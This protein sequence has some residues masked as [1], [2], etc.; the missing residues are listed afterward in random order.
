[1]R[2]DELELAVGRMLHARFRRIPVFVGISGRAFP[3][4]PECGILNHFL[5]IPGGVIW[6]A[7]DGRQVVWMWEPRDSDGSKSGDERV[8]AAR[9]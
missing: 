9:L 2:L 3:Y 8:V 1:M 4:A 6:F 7:V 5:R